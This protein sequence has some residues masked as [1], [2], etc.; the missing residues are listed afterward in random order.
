MRMR[1]LQVTTGSL[2]SPLPAG[3]EEEEGGEESCTMQGCRSC[4]GVPPPYTPAAGRNRNRERE[5]GDNMPRD[6]D[7][8]GKKAKKAKAESKPLDAF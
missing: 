1:L 5:R 3:G 6:T 8:E 4:T 7:T 2:E